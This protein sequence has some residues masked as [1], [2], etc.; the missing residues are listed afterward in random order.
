MSLSPLSALAFFAT[1]VTAAP[2]EAPPASGGAAEGCGSEGYRLRVQGEEVASCPAL[3]GDLEVRERNQR[4]RA[5]HIARLEASADSWEVVVRGPPMREPSG[6]TSFAAVEVKGTRLAEVDVERCGD[7]DDAS[8]HRV[9]WV[10]RVELDGELAR[11]CGGD[12]VWLRKDDAF[13][14]RG[15]VL[16]VRPSGLLLAREDRLVFLPTHQEEDAPPPDFDV[17]YQSSFRVLAAPTKTSPV[18]RGR[19]KAPARKATRR[20]GRRR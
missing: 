6:P 18:P 5:D 8:A 11:L 4:W 7:D 12:E 15:R 13:G 14:R 2:Q 16:A 20:R 3:F 1:A 9:E 10:A 17:V 19:A